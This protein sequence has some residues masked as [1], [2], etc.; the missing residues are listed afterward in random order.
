MM[1]TCL[2]HILLLKVGT[3][4]LDFASAV[5]VD[6]LAIGEWEGVAFYISVKREAIQK[7]LDLFHNSRSNGCGNDQD[8][9]YQMVP[10]YPT[11]KIV[12]DTPYTLAL[13]M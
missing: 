2:L 1:L 4:Y 7:Q 9:L 12:I 6:G 8:C 11:Y 5:L 13:D 10:S 3:F